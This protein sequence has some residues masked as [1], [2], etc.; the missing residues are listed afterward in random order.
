MTTVRVLSTLLV[1]GRVGLGGSR[2]W[3]LLKRK[4][5]LRFEL[6]TGVGNNV[7]GGCGG[8]AESRG[9]IGQEGAMLRVSPVL[10]MGRSS[11]DCCA[12]WPL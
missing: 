9:A 1:R 11:L 10:S 5:Y 12:L 3:L 4:L 6:A 8:G 2:G 7:R